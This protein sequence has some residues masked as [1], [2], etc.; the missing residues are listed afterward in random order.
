M[1][2]QDEDPDIAPA[3]LQLSLDDDGPPVDE[4]VL[5]GE[6]LSFP[7]AYQGTPQKRLPADV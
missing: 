6:A 7:Q 2:E 4:V 5:V 1:A 3:L